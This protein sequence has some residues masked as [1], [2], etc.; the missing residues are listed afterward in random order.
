MPSLIPKEL[1]GE[2]GAPGLASSAGFLETWEETP[3]LQWPNSVRIYDLMRKTDAQIGS[4][5]RAIRLP[6]MG[7]HWGLVGDDVR[8]EVT[9]LVERD[10]GLDR[11]NAKLGRRR[12]RGQRVNWREF[13]SHVLLGPI[14]GHMPFEKVYE[15][16]PPP[17]DV[18]GTMP[19][20]VAHLAKLGPR[21]PR[22]LWGVA[23]DAAG[24]LQGIRQWVPAPDPGARVNQAYGWDY[25]YIHK[26]V[27][28]PAN[29]LA[30]FSHEREGSDWLG[31]SILREAYKHWMLKD[32]LIRVDAMAIERNGM[33]VPAVKYPQGG[34]EK[35]ALAV[36][37]SYRASENAGIAYPDDMDVTLLAVQG[38]IRDALPSIKYHDESAGRAALAM[39]LN[40]GHDKGARSLG[41]TFVDFFTMA[42]NAEI[43]M[44]E[45]FVTEEVIRDLVALN[46]GD[47]EPYPELKGEDLTAE[48]M[49]TAEGLAALGT[50]GMLTRDDPLENDLR[51]RFGFP[52]LSITA[53]PPEADP[54]GEEG[55]ATDVKPED[56]PPIP[57]PSGAQ[58]PTLASAGLSLDQVEARL[59]AAR[60]RITDR[61]LAAAI[62]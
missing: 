54:L 8:P 32:V 26:L 12:T 13:L 28:I 56:T 44:V 10:L 42:L 31:S 5:A 40:L 46:F 45:E 16:G 48:S 7:T 11:Q 37:R 4:V 17:D 57:A 39:F 25:G 9:A 43:E 14:Y 2:L 22:S 47:E 23:V 58:G 19:E 50:A 49:P 6:I 3:E 55:A 41:D 21:M 18:A 15:V 34:D 29:R 61:A 62:R 27:D 52:M 33:G 53:P 60:K 20:Y 38:S 36:A 51:R 24:D 30:F 59:A 1:A 35:K